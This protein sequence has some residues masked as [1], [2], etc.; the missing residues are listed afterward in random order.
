MLIWAVFGMKWSLTIY[1]QQHD[2]PSNAQVHRHSCE[3]AVRVFLDGLN[4]RYWMH[5]G[6]GE[7]RS[8]RLLHFTST[9]L[10][11]VRRARFTFQC[12]IRS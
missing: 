6:G 10:S 8:L 1:A 11:G 3:F 7:R 9:T 12:W 2:L 4:R 5:P